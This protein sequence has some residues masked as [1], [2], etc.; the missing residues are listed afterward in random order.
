MPNFTLNMFLP[1]GWSR[2]VCN[3]DEDH[4]H[5]RATAEVVPSTSTNITSNTVIITLN[6]NQQLNPLYHW[7]IP[8]VNIFFKFTKQL[9]L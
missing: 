4:C 9:P 3:E 1:N 2:A 5:G 8:A 7:S 6:F